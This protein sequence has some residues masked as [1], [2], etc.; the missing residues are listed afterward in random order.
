M[1]SDRIKALLGPH[2]ERER[3]GAPDAY[4]RWMRVDCTIDERDDIFRFF[5]EHPIAANPVREYL[6]DGWRTLS[7]LL[8]LL[9]RCG[10]P[11]SEINSILEA[12]AGFGR[13]TRHLAKAAPGRVACTEIV[14]G[15]VQFLRERFGVE[16]YESARDPA[17]I[18]WPRRYELVFV[19]S[20][21]THLPLAVWR[22]WIRQLAAAT[23]PGGLLVFTTHSPEQAAAEGVK[24]DADG[25]RFFASSENRAL[26]AGDYGTTFTTRERVLRE[27]AAALPGA[28]VE[29][30]PQAFWHGQDAVV[31]KP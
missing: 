28:S 7:E 1:K 17:D 2:N 11:L 22:G 10:R 8:L 24:F 9:E 29:I 13:F 14:P 6:A 15:A 12:A 30:H 3:V 20:L 25:A 19:L 27:V 31:V 18:A 23:E 4:G 21:F 16:A 26:D 5:A